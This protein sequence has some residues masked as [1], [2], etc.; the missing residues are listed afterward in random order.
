MSVPN[1]IRAGAKLPGYPALTHNWLVERVHGLLADRDRN[2]FPTRSVDPAPQVLVRNTH[3]STVN[4]HYGILAT[5]VALNN[6]TDYQNEPY[7]GIRI[8]GVAP[9]DT[10]GADFVVLQGSAKVDH[11]SPA[12]IQGPTWVR[13]DIKTAGD[14]SCGVQT[15]DTDRLHSDA[16]GAKILWAEKQ[17][18]TGNETGEQWAIIL[19]GSVPPLDILG[20]IVAIGLD[21]P[22]MT[23][24]GDLSNVNG[25]RVTPGKTGSADVTDYPLSA[26]GLLLDWE[27]ED[28]TAA[29]YIGSPYHI[30]FAVW[31]PVYEEVE[32]QAQAQLAIRAVYNSSMT[33]IRGS[34][35]D[36]VICQGRED[37]KTVGGFQYKMFIVESVMDLRTLPGY[38]TG[39]AP[40]GPDDPDLQIPFHSGGDAAFKLDSEEC[41]P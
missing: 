10:T 40:T 13:V 19:V 27:R 32:G 26:G 14:K 34:V 24:N 30:A 29:G 31:A 1:R 20:G 8:D 39:T 4:V 23:M 22:A 35:A 36:P 18:D 2:S 16:T 41:A 7:N 37:T 38:A 5:D 12:V 17:D 25:F 15:D 21:I 11:F 28:Q 6:P 9:T 3:T 33:R